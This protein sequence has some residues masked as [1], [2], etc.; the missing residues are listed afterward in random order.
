MTELIRVVTPGGIT[1]LQSGLLKKAG[2]Q[3][4]FSTRTGGVSEAPFASLNL[5]Q[6]AAEG[7]PDPLDNIEENL[8]RFVAATGLLE[9]RLVRLRQVHGC[10][11]HEVSDEEVQPLSCAD[12]SVSNCPRCS[13]I[14]RTADCVA[15]LL[16]C[17]RTNSV[18]AVHA[19]WRGLVAGVVGATISK[20][21]S[22][23]GVAPRDLVAAIGPAIS[24][25]S[26]PVGPE[27]TA[28]FQAAGLGQCALYGRVDCGGAAAAQLLAAG[29]RESHIDR[30]SLC[31]YAEKELFHSARRDGARSGRLGALIGC[32]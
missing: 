17:P 31:T 18:A 5:G 29:V 13:L 27:V 22:R 9:R 2:F 15:I 3:H 30:S 1:L 11:V 23:F 10:V 4:A 8:R 12:A 16:A 21:G 19:G 25:E 14:V 28:A 26:Y 7:L 20:L 6:A 24:A 32:A